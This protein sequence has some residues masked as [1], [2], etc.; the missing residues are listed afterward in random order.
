MTPQITPACADQGAFV[1]DLI[2]LPWRERGAGPDAYDC[3][4]LAVHVQREL[5]NR[6]LPFSDAL[7]EDGQALREIIETI[8]GSELQRLWQPVETPAHGDLVIMAQGVFPNH[9]GVWV[10]C[11]AGMVGILHCTQDYGVALETKAQVLSLYSRVAFHRCFTPEVEQVRAVDRCHLPDLA[12]GPIGIVVEDVV[13]PLSG[14]R[15]VPLEVGARIETALAGLDNPDG[16]WVVLNDLPLL[17][18]NPETRENELLRPVQAGDIVWVLPPLPL[19][20][21]RGSQVLA[22]VLAIVVTLVAPMATA[23]ILGKAG[24]ATL[25]GKLLTAGIAIA[26]QALISS[27]V[28]EAPTVTP[29]ANPNPTYSF[30]SFGNQMRAGAQVPRPYGTFKRE[31]DFLAPPWADYERNEQIV[32]VLLHVGAGEHEVLEFGTDDTPIWT[33]DEGYTGAVAEI[34]HEIAQPGEDITLFPNSVEVSPEVDGI[35]MPINVELGP[36]AAVSSGETATQLVCDFIF[37]AGLFDVGD[38]LQYAS[39]TWDVIAQQIDDFGLSVGD[40]FTLDT[41]FYRRKTT[42]PQRLTKRYDVPEGRYQVSVIRTSASNV[43]GNG[44]DAIAWAALKAIY[45]TQTPYE[46]DTALAIRVRA[47]STSSASLTN[48][49]VRSRAILPYIEPETG[50]IV[51]GPT[52]QIDAAVLHIARWENGL[53]LSDEQIDIPQLTDL[54]RTWKNRGDVCC[55]LIESELTAWEVLELVMA[56]GR[57]KP[58]FKGSMLTFMRDEARRPTRLITHADMVRG[59][60]EVE[61]KHY[62]RESPVVVRMR[63]RDRDGSMQSMLCPNDPTES[64][65]AEVVTQVMVDA[66]QVWREGNYLAA[67][68]RLRRRFPGWIGLAGAGSLVPGQVVKVAHPR[69]NYGRPA[70]VLAVN[71]FELDLSEPHCLDLGQIGWLSLARPDGSMWGPVQAVGTSDPCV[72][73]IDENDFERVMLGDEDGI[74]DLDFRNWII[75]EEGGR[76]SGEYGSRQAEAT[77]ASVGSDGKRDLDVVIVAVTPQAGG[78]VEVLAVQEDA[79]VHTADLEPLPE[80]FAPTTLEN[81]TAPDWNGVLIVGISNGSGYDLVIEGPDVPSASAYVIELS[82]TIDEPVFEEVGRTTEPTYSGITD[83]T[84]DVLVRVAAVGTLLRGPSSTFFV[85]IAAAVNGTIIAVEET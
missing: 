59:S 13:S 14:A 44:Q 25:G 65:V 64:R 50:N 12:D 85:E 37:P 72:V 53:A 51:T 55:T 6:D 24:A 66:E 4:G 48:W 26:G 77:R 83:I 32:H 47:A 56:A 58:V 54:A 16:W 9:I 40:P 60:F 69:P 71:D 17:R 84:A 30:G 5:F 78:R 41:I 21:G 33:S 57:A 45:S 80:Q 76:I 81:S 2:G 82:E 61:R 43:G 8:R 19:G 3:W 73:A 31:P 67:T 62:M 23:A 74:Y 18:C 63:Y 29:L 46:K 10:D 38:K 79:E 28:P 35:E 7:V 20:G 15:F 36:F 42:T 22:S 27:F 11:G 34:E 49:Y 39:V 68:N 70:R 1:A 52:E 75:S